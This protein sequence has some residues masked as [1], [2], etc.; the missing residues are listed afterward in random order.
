MRI[1][2]VWA[3]AGVVLLLGRASVTLTWKGYQEILASPQTLAG[4]DWAVLVS[5]I[6]FFVWGEGWL[7]LHR[8][9]APR[10]LKRI[11]DLAPTTAIGT[12]LPGPLY[13]MGLVG[14]PRRTLIR[15]W[16]GV[17][18][19]VMAV[20]L[21]R[22]MHQPWRAMVKLGVGGALALG[23]ASLVLRAVRAVHAAPS[24]SVARV[25]DS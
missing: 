3:F 9:W 20:V 24:E 16:I 8:R 11:L 1:A 12:V 15:T 7:A 25:R 14:A 19:I 18:T 23:V 17:A 6:V 4:A 5:V 2:R 13:A 10:V 21:V 22:A